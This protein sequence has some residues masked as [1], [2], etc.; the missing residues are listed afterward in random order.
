M[1]GTGHVNLAGTLKHSLDCGGVTLVSQGQGDAFSCVLDADDAGH[2]WSRRMGAAGTDAANAVAVDSLGNWLLTGGFIGEIQLGAQPQ[3]HQQS[4]GAHDIFIVKYDP[5]GNDLWAKRFGDGD[6]EWGGS[7]AIDGAGNVF[8]TG[9]CNGTINFGDA[10]K[11]CDYRGIFVVKLAPSGEYVWSKV[12]K[13]TA[14][15]SAFD[16]A[17]DS[18]GNVVLTG[19]LQGSINFGGGMLTSAGNTDIFVVKLNALGE[20]VWSQLFGDAT[21]QSGESVAVDSVGN[22]LVTGGF[23]GYTNFGSGPLVSAGSHDVFVAKLSSSG[24]HVWSR[25]FGADDYDWGRDVAVDATGNVLLTGRF[26][27][28]VDFGG[29]PLQSA[30]GTDIYVAKLTAAGDTVWS[31]SFGTASSDHAH[32]IASDGDGNVVIAGEAAGLF[33]AKLSK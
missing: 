4:A 19:E 3:S 16:I 14:Q 8:V 25:S 24:L 5:N 21:S 12:F 22:V 7:I 9:V 17:A 28:A 23:D 31:R 20:H 18:S 13:A 6:D 2:R 30:G 10:F 33:V 27:G 32:S 1:D 15:S 26:Q 29:G 11:L